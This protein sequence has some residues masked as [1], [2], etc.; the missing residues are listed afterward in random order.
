MEKIQDSPGNRPVGMFSGY[1]V[2]GSFGQ[3]VIV[4]PSGEQSNGIHSQNLGQVKFSKGEW[5]DP[6]RAAGKCTQALG[7]LLRAMLVSRTDFPPP[8]LVKSTSETEQQACILSTSLSMFSTRKICDI[9]IPSKCL[10]DLPAGFDPSDHD[11]AISSFGNRLADDVGRLSF[12]FSP[13]DVR[14]SFLLGLLNNKSCSFGILLS[15]LLLFDG[16]GKLAAKGHVSD[17]DVFKSDVEL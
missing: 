15:D 12:S 6:Y 3:L 1:K 17:G 14:L 7:I 5:Y 4:R 16:S 13:D 11:Q 8:L 10:R 9:W 2:T